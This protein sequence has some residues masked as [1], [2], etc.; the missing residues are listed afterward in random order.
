MSRDLSTSLE[1]TLFRSQNKL[2]IVLRQGHIKAK[3][4]LF[5]SKSRYKNLL[6]LRHLS[7]E[8][9]NSK[10]GDAYLNTQVSRSEEPCLETWTLNVLRYYHRSNFLK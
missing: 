3:L 2:A 10:S 7:I 5:S 6:V 8:A 1:T 4:V 9:K